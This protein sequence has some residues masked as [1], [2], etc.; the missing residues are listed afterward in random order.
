[1]LPLMLPCRTMSG[2]HSLPTA[3]PVCFAGL[4]HYS[5]APAVLLMNCLNLHLART[6]GAPPLIYAASGTESRLQAR[7]G[8]LTLTTQELPQ[9]C[10]PAVVVL[11]LLSVLLCNDGM[12]ELCMLRQWQK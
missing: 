10:Q 7:P 1:M 3:E 2:A 11:V 8:K 12:P 9:S 4:Q 5:V 6:S